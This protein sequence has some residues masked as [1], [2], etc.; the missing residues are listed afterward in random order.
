MIVEKKMEK[1]ARIEWQGINC[2]ALNGVKDGRR[3]EEKFITLQTPCIKSYSPKP[4][5]NVAQVV[6]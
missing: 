1:N 4:R 5:T 6:S 2:I 3:K